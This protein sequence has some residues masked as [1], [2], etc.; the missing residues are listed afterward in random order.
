MQDYCLDMALKILAHKTK[1][2]ASHISIASTF[3][4]QIYY[5]AA[6]DTTGGWEEYSKLLCDA[7]WILVPIN[8]GMAG[9][10]SSAI[11]GAHWSLLALNRVAKTAHYFDSLFID[12]SNYHDL[13]GTVFRGV[14]NVLGENVNDWLCK[15]EYFSPNQTQHNLCKEDAWTSCGPFVFMMI[16]YQVDTIMW[17]QQEGRE[18]QH[19][20]DLG[21]DFPLKW[22]AEW[23]S[24][25]TRVDMQDSIAQMKKAVEA[26]KETGSGD[27]VVEM[28][29]EDVKPP[30]L[31]EGLDTVVK[32][33]EEVDVDAALP[34]IDEAH[35]P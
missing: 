4:S 33:A 17:A 29:V 22:G 25:G 19:V 5:H 6:F 20:L 7:K 28:A 8:D 3:E 1:C 18:Y 11:H 15:V 14:V 21:E 35:A 13:A 27:E 34:T 31:G 32:E 2:A 26:E 30:T 24:L 23:N 10:S 12:N 16:K 9:I